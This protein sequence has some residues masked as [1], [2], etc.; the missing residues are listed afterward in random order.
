MANRVLLGQKG[1]DY[2]LWVSKPGKN[3][4]TAND[5]E[6]MLFSSTSATNQYGEVLARGSYTF[7][8]TSGETTSVTVTMRDNTEPYVIWY[9]QVSSTYTPI[10]IFTSSIETTYS[11]PSTNSCTIQFKKYGGVS[12][13]V[14]YIITGIEI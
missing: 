8:S 13:I 1:S 5:P 4:L 3:V 10:N 14:V 9:Y 2:G 6:D 7:G 11:F 12:G